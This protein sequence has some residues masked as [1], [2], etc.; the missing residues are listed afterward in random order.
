MEEGNWQNKRMGGMVMGKCED[1]QRES[2]Y[3]ETNLNISKNDMEAYNFALF[4][5]SMDFFKERVS[6]KK[7][8]PKHFFTSLLNN[9]STKDLVTLGNLLSTEFMNPWWW[10]YATLSRQAWVPQELRNKVLKQ[11]VNR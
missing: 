6:L 7:L 2:F 5:H 11:L 1:G 8:I 3:N 9:L 10:L 4:T